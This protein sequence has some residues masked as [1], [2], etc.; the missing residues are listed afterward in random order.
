[1]LNTTICQIEISTKCNHNCVFCPL[2]TRY[3]KRCK[4]VM[5][6]PLFKTLVTKIKIDAPYIDTL[7]INGMGEPFEDLDIYDKIEFAVKHFKYIHLVTN[8]S[9]IDLDKFKNYLNYLSSITISLHSL[10]NTIFEQITGKN[11]LLFTLDTIDFINK[12]KVDTKVYITANIISDNY[13]EIQD[14]ISMENKCDL[15]EIQYAHNW[16]NIFAYQQLSNKMQM[17]K[18]PFTGSVYIQVNGAINMCS[19]DCNGQ[20]YLG[21]L[22]HKTINQIFSDYFYEKLKYY[23][24]VNKFNNEPCSNCDQRNFDNNIIIYSSNL[25]LSQNKNI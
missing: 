20:L 16:S 7:V 22:K 9:L 14:L 2:N 23:H 10:S 13:S 6:T 21:D 15:L 18:I 12:H 4:M 17:C 5:D 3:F 11:N 1:M 8:G 24:E 25:T 19:Y